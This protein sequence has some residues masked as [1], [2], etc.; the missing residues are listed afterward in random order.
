MTRDSYSRRSWTPGLSRVPTPG[1]PQPG[2]REALVLRAGQPSSNNVICLLVE[3]SAPQMGLLPE[4]DLDLIWAWA[5]AELMPASFRRRIR[6]GKMLGVDDVEELLTPLE[7]LLDKG[8]EHAVLLIPVVEEGADMAGTGGAPLR[9]AEPHSL[10]HSSC[11]SDRVEWR[12][13]LI[14]APSSRAWELNQTS[15]PS[16]SIRIRIR[17]ATLET[18]IFRRANP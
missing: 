1:W 3:A 14:H 4:P 5:A 9:P 13:D 11:P 15:I 2:P 16:S 10:A 17:K 18:G 12:R 8:E 7:P 6:S